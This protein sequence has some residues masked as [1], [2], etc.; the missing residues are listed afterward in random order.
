MGSSKK[1]G[2]PRTKLK[3]DSKPSFK[4]QPKPN[5]KIEIYNVG[6]EETPETNANKFDI[7]ESAIM[8]NDNTIFGNLVMKTKLDI[9]EFTNG[10]LNPDGTPKEERKRKSRK[11]RQKKQDTE[12]TPML[13]SAYL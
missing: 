11:S 9:S 5:K 8:K 13:Y 6:Y 12:E 1:P 10:S 3:S 4:Q 2:S 7:D